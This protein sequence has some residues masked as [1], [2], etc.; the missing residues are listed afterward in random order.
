MSPAAAFILASIL[1]A[2]GAALGWLSAGGAVAAV[3]VGTTVL[4]GSGLQGGALLGLFFVSGSLFT[5]TGRGSR[6]R[7]R[8][9]GGRVWPQV[10]ANG[11]WAAAGAVLVPGEPAI[12]WPLLVGGLTAAQADTWGTEVGRF[13]RSPPRLITSGRIVD[14]GT[15][16]GVTWLGS[17]AG[18][19]GAGLMAATAVLVG[20][21]M[22][23]AAAG[24]AGGVAGAMA[25]SILGATV[26][27]RYQCVACGAEVERAAHGCPDEAVLAGGVR[28]IDNDAVNLL[29]TTVG[30]AGALGVTAM[31]GA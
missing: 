7:R 3:L 29:A 24:L 17:A 18:V 26:Q 19:A 11:G 5:A 28:W 21:P 10:I 14:H 4:W 27:G 30:A 9:H 23:V 13:S 8:R 1:A 22:A 6:S 2:A 12:G 15:S 31:L 16:G 25:D 20:V